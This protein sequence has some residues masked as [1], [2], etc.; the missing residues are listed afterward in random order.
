MCVCLKKLFSVK[1]CFV[2]PKEKIES[3]VTRKGLRPDTKI[4]KV[5]LESF[6][7]KNGRFIVLQVAL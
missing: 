7:F 3:E 6:H 4:A 1:V 5:N 2:V